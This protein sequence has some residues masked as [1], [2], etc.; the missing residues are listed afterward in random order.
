[1]RATG[2]P[3]ACPDP[4]LPASVLAFR[5][6]SSLRSTITISFAP[7]ITNLFNRPRDSRPTYTR[8]SHPTSSRFSNDT[9]TRSRRGTKL[10]KDPRRQSELRRNVPKGQPHR[11]MLFKP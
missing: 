2:V 7:D 9:A 10:G 3:V 1:M 8:K 11:L 4:L 5:E 6:C